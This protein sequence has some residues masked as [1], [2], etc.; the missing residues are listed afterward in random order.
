MRQ[1]SSTV[2]LQCCV[3]RLPQRSSVLL[4][5]E[6]LASHNAWFKRTGYPVVHSESRETLR[7]SNR[8]SKWRTARLPMHWSRVTIRWIV[9]VNRW[10][11]DLAV[12]SERSIVRSFVSY[13]CVP[14]PMSDS[15][16][17]IIVVHHHHH[18]PPRLLSL[19]SYLFLWS[20]EC[21]YVTIFLRF[22]RFAS[23]KYKQVLF[24]CAA[25]ST[26]TILP[27]FASSRVSHYF[28]VQ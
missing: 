25:I 13:C 23:R 19:P 20:I 21:S 5:E 27:R 1:T 26:L 4:P 22:L 3:T 28:F 17:I 12:I 2:W 14:N 8:I 16:T 9:R 24:V 7:H 10:R 11:C 15:V 6:I 18:P